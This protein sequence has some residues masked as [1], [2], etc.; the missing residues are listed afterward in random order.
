[1]IYTDAMNKKLLLGAVLLAIIA[2]AFAYVLLNKPA[3]TTEKHDM[4]HMAQAAQAPASPTTS[5]TTPGAYV[6][7]S[8]TVVAKTSGVK[9]I[10]FYA[11]WCPQCRMLDADIKAGSIPTGVTIIK[12]DYDSN[13]G[14]RQK[15]G[16]TIQT[17]IVR[18]DDAGNLL[19]KYVAY[20]DPTLAAV[21]NGALK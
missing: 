13:Q 12:T 18:V 5:A 20:D 8:P 6:D 14:L 7:Y 11:P 17:T 15:Y 21:I 2:S 1:M 10:F 19:Q 16:V 9:L 3:V 4:S